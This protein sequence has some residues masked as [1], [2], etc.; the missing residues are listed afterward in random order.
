MS[1]HYSVVPGGE[2]MMTEQQVER[3]QVQ[4]VFGLGGGELAD[5][6]WDGVSLYWY[7]GPPEYA[8]ADGLDGL[9]LDDDSEYRTALVCCL[10]G[11][12]PAP[13]GWS[14]AGSYTTSG[15]ADCWWCGPGTDWDGSDE[16]DRVR[17]ETATTNT[18]YRG[19]VDCPLCEGDGWV[20]L[21]DGW[22]E[23]VYRRD[24]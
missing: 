17:G 3:E 21:G 16:Q 22:A 11:A 8:T 7:E 20:Y 10:F 12:P 15:E 6:A 14:V 23:V 4:N 5:D 18:H 2:T 1:R 19:K 24:A 9:D 13:D